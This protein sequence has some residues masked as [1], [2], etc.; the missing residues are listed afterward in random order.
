MFRLADTPVY[1]VNLHV[2]GYRR[3]RTPEIA[4]VREV[5][6]TTGQPDVKKRRVDFDVDGV[7]ETRIYTREQ[8]QVGF[9][10]FV[11]PEDP[12]PPREGR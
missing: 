7:H 5:G 9:A 11:L 12:D 1:F 6:P 10:A 4:R 8:L 3:V 2:I